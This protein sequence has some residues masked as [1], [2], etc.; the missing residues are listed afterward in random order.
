MKIKRRCDEM[1]PKGPAFG[2]ISEGR[3]FG[4]VCVIAT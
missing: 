2:V 4:M 1:I 3:L